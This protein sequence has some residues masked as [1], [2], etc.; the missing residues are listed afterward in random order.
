LVYADIFDGESSSAYDPATLILLAKTYHVGP[1]L[2]LVETYGA[3]VY[4]APL[5]VMPPLF[6]NPMYVFTLMVAI[7]H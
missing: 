7:G 3:P 6:Y 5:A 1:N 2:Y 4:Y